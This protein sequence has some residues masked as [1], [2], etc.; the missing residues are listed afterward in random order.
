MK[1]V[2]EG[3]RE[4]SPYSRHF[5]SSGLDYLPWSLVKKLIK[6]GSWRNKNAFPQPHSCNSTEGLWI[7]K[8]GFFSLHAS[9]PIPSKVPNDCQMRIGILETKSAFHVDSLPSSQEWRGNNI[10]GWKSQLFHLRPIRLI[11][12]RMDFC[13]FQIQVPSLAELLMDEQKGE[14]I[15]V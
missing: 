6:C 12:K 3:V 11:T 5:L 2:R 1:P 10:S 7:T 13:S 15:G 14:T 4:E 8:A 9:Q